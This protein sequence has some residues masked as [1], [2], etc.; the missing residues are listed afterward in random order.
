MDCEA[1][2]SV[3]IRDIP[4]HPDYGVSADGRIWSR[5]R[6]DWRA[7]KP[8]PATHRTRA[9]NGEANGASKLTEHSVREMRDLHAY[10]MSSADLARKYDVSSTQVFRIISWAAWMHI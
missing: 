1:D 6:G 7:M 9:T 4:K 3:E 5:C 8:Q 2:V 10:G